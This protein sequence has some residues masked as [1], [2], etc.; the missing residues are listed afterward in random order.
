[1]TRSTNRI[2]VTFLIL[3]ITGA[4][5]E[6]KS[7]AQSWCTVFKSISRDG[8][9]FDEYGY[10]VDIWG[11]YAVIGARSEETDSVGGNLLILAGAAYF[12]EKDIMGEWALTQKVS[13][14]D[15]ENN[16]FFGHSVSISGDFAVISAV[17]K[18]DNDPKVINNSG[19]A[20]LYEREINGHWK[21]ILK[22]TASDKDKKAEFGSSVSISGDYIIIGAVSEE[23]DE[24]GGNSLKSAGAAYIFEKDG[25]GQWKEVQKIVASDRSE[26]DLFGG[27]VSISGDYLLVGA[28][29]HDEGI[30]SEAGATYVFE[31]DITGK[32]IETQ[33][34]IPTNYGDMYYFGSSVSLHNNYAIVGAY[35]DAED[36]EGKD[37]I[38]NGGSAHIFKRSVAGIWENLQ[39]ITAS[40]RNPED[41]FGWSV[42]I[43]NKFAVIGARNKT[44]I[45]DTGTPIDQAGAV[46][47]FENDGADTWSQSNKIIPSD[48]ESF[49]NFGYAV[50]SYGNSILASSPYKTEMDTVTSVPLVNTGAVYFL[51]PC[52]NIVII[53]DT[54]IC[55]GDSILL[56][57][58]FRKTPGTYYD[59]IPLPEGNDSI[60]VTNLTIN[61]VFDI[62][63]NESICEG[64]SIWLEDAFRS[65]SGNYFDTLITVNGCDS[66]VIT[67][68]TIIQ[69]TETQIDTS[70]CRG[71]SIWLEGDYRKLP[72]IYFDTILVGPGCDNVIITTL[73]VNSLPAVDLGQDTTICEGDF[74]LL[75]A[76][77]GYIDYSWNN[78]YANTQTISADTA[79]TYYVRVTDNNGCT[80]TDT[81]TIALKDCSTAV[82]PVNPF[83]ET[84]VFPNPTKGLLN[85]NL[86]EFNTGNEV[87]IS[88]INLLGK[89]IL[90][91]TVYTQSKTSFDLSG[92][93]KGIYF[94]N[95][96]NNISNYTIKIMLE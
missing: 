60:I 26:N 50:G 42:A 37:F 39:K 29:H 78:G 27:S 69:P 54:S 74:L 57:G 71:D 19:A 81:V 96:S 92:I 20:Y 4:V 46:Y 90:S 31:C 36:F 33:K 72:G 67:N 91:N 94:V 2:I 9:G 75:D 17:G 7:Y 14:P 23:R 22:M 88:I 51:E 6:I 35:G 62:F 89:V 85:I 5:W 11:D 55:Q 44:I 41:W 76:G 73:E 12:Y 87:K 83:H 61:P 34:L 1:M 24:T 65:V 13:A 64:D 77:A 48:I 40:D 30:I 25:F 43:N 45:P 86:G 66:V 79:G 93:S 84:V 58:A 32:W 8:D 59:S 82:T 68:L 63:I 15:R 16:D 53:N 95:I 38:P 21:L 80:G 10:S 47:V 52:E 18:D 3:M 56:A 49:N 70:I 28:A